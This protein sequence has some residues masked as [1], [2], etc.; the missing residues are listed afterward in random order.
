MRGTWACERAGSAYR[1]C[2]IRIP[3]PDKSHTIIPYMVMSMSGRTW[4]LS[5]A[6][7]AF[8]TSSRIVVYRH[9][10]GCVG[11]EKGD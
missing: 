1:N 8:S 2:Y 6:S 11:E 4:M 5:A 3:Y 7:S 9:F 10:P